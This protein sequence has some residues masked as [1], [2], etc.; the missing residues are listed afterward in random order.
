MPDRTETGILYKYIAKS[1]GKVSLK[2]AKSILSENLSIGK[3]KIAIDVLTEL[4]II[5]KSIENDVTYLLLNKSSGKVDLA[6]SIIIKRLNL[7]K[8]GKKDD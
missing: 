4:G 2:K 6:D 5:E 8:E 7:I 3:V 1:N